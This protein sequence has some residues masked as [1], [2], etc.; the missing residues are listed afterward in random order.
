MTV[1]IAGDQIVDPTNRA[2]INQILATI[3]KMESGGNYQQLNKTATASGAYQYVNGTWVSKSKAV[4]GANSYPRAYQAPPAVQD[5]VAEAD[6]RAILAATGNHLA[7][8]PIMWYYPIS[9]PPREGTNKGEIDY[10]PPG[11][12]LTVRKYAESW[13]HSYQLAGPVVGRHLVDPVTGVPI[14]PNQP[15][16]GD[17]P[18]VGGAVQGIWNTITSP[19]DALKAA[20]AFITDTSLWMRILKVI[21]GLIAIGM[22]IW[23]VT[24]DQPVAAGKALVGKTAVAAAVI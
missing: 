18:L 23:I 21:G 4:A 6:V 1:T 13:L 19:L 16:L 8:V 17:I 9:W 24:H 3:R 15:T 11:N 2:V 10:T 20:L 5:A 14:D 22:G 12:P 7:A